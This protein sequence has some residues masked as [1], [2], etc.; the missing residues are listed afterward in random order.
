MIKFVTATVLTAL[1][2]FA[3][4]L[5]LPWWIIALVAF[6]VAAAI[7][8]KPLLAFLSAAIAL[9]LLWSIQSFIID[10]RNNHLLATKVAELLTHRKSYLLI[11]IIT[12]IVG[13]TVSGFAALTG[14]LFRKVLFVKR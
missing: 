4:S 13:A 5:F 10:K 7:P 1:L 3:T 14:S 8:Q 2:S 9:F 11:I 6:V 12:G